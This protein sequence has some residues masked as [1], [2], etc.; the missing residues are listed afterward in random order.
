MLRADLPEHLRGWLLPATGK[1][2][3]PVMCHWG[4]VSAGGPTRGVGRDDTVTV[5]AAL[6]LVHLFAL[7]HDD[8]MDRSDSRRGRPT[9]HVEAA[10]EHTAAGALG[11]PAL[12][13]DSIAILFGDLA[14]TESWVLTARPRRRRSSVRGPTCC[15]SWCR[16]SC[17]TSPA[18]PPAAAT[19]PRRAGWPAS[20]RAPTPCSGRS[21]LGALAARAEA[22]A[23]AALE[24]FGGHLGEAFAL[25]DD[26]LGVW[27]DPERTGK[28]VGDDLL[29]GKATVLLA[30]ARRLLPERRRRALPR[31]PSGHHGRR[32]RGAPAADARRRRPRA[33]RAAHHPRGRPR[34][35]CSRPRST[36]TPRG[37]TPCGHSP[38][39]IAWRDA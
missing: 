29:R 36:S 30:E 16:A 18:P 23:L 31:A 27:G 4:W 7:V 37:R 12:F 1:R 9:T 10:E 34:P 25:R 39:R 22:D 17:S 33:G 26:M 3:R 11:D 15:A 19:S 32:R 28:P 13:G 14:L 6:E 24:T 35:H 38:D 2:L 20:S 8:V 21:L 5:C